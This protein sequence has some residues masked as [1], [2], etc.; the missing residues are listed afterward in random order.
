MTFRARDVRLMGKG[1][2]SSGFRAMALTTIRHNLPAEPNR[3]IGRERDIDELRSFLDAARAVTLCGVGGIGKTRLALHVVAMLADAFP[4][5]A[6]LVELGD[7]RQP[8]L[9]VPRVAA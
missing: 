8:E 7:V 4:D 3:F 5:G 9:V 1:G 2:S 6:W